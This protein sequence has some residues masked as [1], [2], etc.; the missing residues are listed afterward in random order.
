MLL[1][2]YDN[3][4]LRIYRLIC[5]AI[6]TLSTALFVHVA[7][8]ELLLETNGIHFGPSDNLVVSVG[9]N[10]EETLAGPVDI[11]LAW[12][13][14]SSQTAFFFADAN[15]VPLEFGVADSGNW[16]ALVNGIQLDA[17]FN[18]GLIPFFNL[19]I[20]SSVAVGDHQFAL[21]L[22][23]AGTLD[24][25]DIKFA[26]VR[27]LTNSIK[28]N[29]G[30]FVGSWN[31]TTFGSSGAASINITEVSPGIVEGTLDLDGFVGGLLDPAPETRQVAVDETG[32]I[33]STSEDSLINGTW[34]LRLTPQ[35]EITIEVRDIGMGFVNFDATGSRVGDSVNLSY[36]VGIAVGTVTG[37]RQ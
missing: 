3:I 37:E 12:V 24:F 1:P 2:N 33:D 20:E 7:Q 30:E 27:V 11:Y 14:P 35:G 36:D 18:T 17:G 28:D 5:H 13:P 19:G 4:L 31:N 34:R 15:P 10:Q 23:N 16:P 8:A 26:N 9:I 21:A 25:I 29:L 6:S 32:L 22:A